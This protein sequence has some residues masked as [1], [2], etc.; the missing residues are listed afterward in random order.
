MKTDPIIIG[1]NYILQ[2]DEIGIKRPNDNV[3][4]V[5]CS[6]TGKSTSTLFPTVARSE[7]SN[8]VMSFAKATDA[9]DM[10]KYLR[11]KGYEVD[12]LDISDPERSTCSFDP[13]MY[14][15]SYQDIT[16]FSSRI[17][18]SALTKTNDDYWNNRSSSF[19]AANT[20]GTF[21][22]SKS[23]PRMI[24]VLE[25]FDKTMLKESFLGDASTDADR[26]FKAIEA[27]A[28]DSMAVRNYNAWASL[29][30][31]TKSCVR[32]TLAGALETTFPESIRHMMEVKHPI[33]F[34][35]LGT[36][37]YALL[38]IS[39]AIE[40]W[41]ECYINLFFSTC[42]LQLL[43]FAAEKC[44]DHHLPR[45]VRLYFDDFSCSCQIAEFE[46]FISLMR[47]AGLSVY[48]LLQ[49][50]SQ[51]EAVYGSDK[52]KIIRQNFP[53]Q[54]YF[55]GGFDYDTCVA[56]SRMMD[57]PVEEI[58]YADI[59][60]VFIMQTGKKPGVY[61]RYATLE[62]EE[63]KEYQKIIHEEVKLKKGKVR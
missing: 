34:D 51:L 52:S 3:L 31:K 33:E 15:E 21:M 39:S 10:A 2:G 40:S 35:K 22:V 4:V 7:R 14:L 41:Q 57:L 20:G 43:R 9:Y 55:P 50:F 62:S 56:V 61:D 18:R 32:D 63:Y 24:D 25:M 60:K 36:E 23:E 28:P 12:I 17:V 29:P 1:K 49:S 5:G 30:D 6:G 38:V 27:K 59:G 54:V 46:H 16:S 26:I 8:P 58:L 19:M 13:I 11:H 47:S 42:I 53:C 48:A 37:K 44:P 45:P